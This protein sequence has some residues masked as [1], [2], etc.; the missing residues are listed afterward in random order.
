MTRDPRI[1]PRSAPQPGDIVL[2]RCVVVALT[3]GRTPCIALRPAGTDMRR[4]RWWWFD[5]ASPE[6]VAEVKP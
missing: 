4:R 1:D 2:L 6:I 5:P 3:S